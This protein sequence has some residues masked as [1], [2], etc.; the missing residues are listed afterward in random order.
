MTV[1]YTIKESEKGVIKVVEASESVTNTW[2][3][4][5]KMLQEEITHLNQRIT[6]ETAERDEKQA[7]LDNILALKV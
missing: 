7:I 1:Q 2:D 4:N 5:V 3:I 6:K